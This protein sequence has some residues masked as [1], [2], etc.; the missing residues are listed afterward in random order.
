M[1][2]VRHFIEVRTSR[3][4][5]G[6]ARVRCDAVKGVIESSAQGKACLILLCDNNVSLTLRGETL[7][8]VFDKLGQAEGRTFVVCDT[9]S[10]EAAATLPPLEPEPPARSTARAA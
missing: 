5:G 7:E 10:V 2:N 4:D 3:A 8:T 6:R 9:P 1:A